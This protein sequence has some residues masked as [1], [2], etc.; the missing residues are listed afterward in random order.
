MKNQFEIECGV[1]CILYVI[2]FLYLQRNPETSRAMDLLLKLKMAGKN[3][4]K[5]KNKNFDFREDSI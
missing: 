3:K 2:Y 4:N 1:E 5:N